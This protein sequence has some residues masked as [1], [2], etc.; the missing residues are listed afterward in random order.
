MAS[1]HRSLK[2]LIDERRERLLDEQVV[3]DENDGDALHRVYIELGERGVMFTV[4]DT[5]MAQVSAIDYLADGIPSELAI[6]EV[7]GGVVARILDA[8]ESWLLRRSAVGISAER[9]IVF[10][11]SEL[12]SWGLRHRGW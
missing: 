11:E 10:I 2:R 1:I 8:L 3:I 6:E 9:L 7:T 5:G 4:W 12:S